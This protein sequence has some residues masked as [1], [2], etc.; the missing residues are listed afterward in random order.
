MDTIYIWHDG[1]HIKSQESTK[2]L[3]ELWVLQDCRIQD[4]LITFLYTN[5]KNVETEIRSNI[6]FTIDPRK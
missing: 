4:K 6:R 2:K 1:L 3:L 5:Y